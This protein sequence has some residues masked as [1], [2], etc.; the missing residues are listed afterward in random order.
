MLTVQFDDIQLYLFMFYYFGLWVSF[1]LVNALFHFTLAQLL[2]FT[3]IS[4]IL[5]VLHYVW[6][7]VLLFV[8]I[9]HLVL[10][11]RHPRW[12]AI[13]LV[14]A[15]VVEIAFYVDLWMFTGEFTRDYILTLMTIFRSIYLMI[16]I[17]WIFYEKKWRSLNSSQ[18]S[19]NSI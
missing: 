6:A 4:S 3:N 7:F 19:M 2:A 11:K 14:I 8:F 10:L 16:T 12:A 13:P 17:R 9:I 5:I 18:S 15:G 1:V